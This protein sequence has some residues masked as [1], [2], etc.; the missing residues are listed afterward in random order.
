MAIESCPRIHTL[1]CV[2]VDELGH[3]GERGNL[4]SA[5]GMRGLP[6]R[7]MTREIR[8]RGVPGEKQYKPDGHKDQDLDE[9]AGI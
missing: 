5:V 2:R 8:Y 7:Y 4:T 6:C 3:V 1:R 9:N